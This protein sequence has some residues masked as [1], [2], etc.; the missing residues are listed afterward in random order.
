MTGQETT[1]EADPNPPE[2]EADRTSDEFQTLNSNRASDFEGETP[3]QPCTNGDCP[4]ADDPRH[5]QE[6][7]WIELMSPVPKVHQSITLEPSPGVAQPNPL[8]F[9]EIRDALRPLGIAAHSIEA[10]RFGW[11]QLHEALKDTPNRLSSKLVDL[12]QE[13]EGDDFDAFAEQVEIAGSN[14]TEALDEIDTAK[15]ELQYLEDRIYADQGGDSCE[16]P[17]PAPDVWRA[18]DSMINDSRIHVRPAWASGDCTKDRGE[19]QSWENL[20]LPQDFT[21]SLEELVDQR[22]E[23]YTQTGMDPTSARLQA[24][25]DYDQSLFDFGEHF[26]ETMK[27]A[28]DQ[29]NEG[30]E[31]LHTDIATAQGD[32][33]LE[34]STRTP[35]A[36]TDIGFKLPPPELIPPPEIDPPPISDFGDY[37]PEPVDPPELPAPDS[38]LGGTP[39]IPSSS[40]LEHGG[41]GSPGS[42]T[43]GTGWDADDNPWGA[44]FDDDDEI[45]GGLASGGAGAPSGLPSGAGGIGAPSSAGP[46]GVGGAMIPGGNGGA[47]AG[48]RGAATGARSATGAGRGRPGMM[49]GGGRGAGSS[50]ENEK[51]RETWLNEDEDVW[52]IVNEDDDPYA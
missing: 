7:T 24:C 15:V 28:S 1:F 37:E 48:G 22:A 49:G 44:A 17:F 26:S 4:Y 12:S 34:H 5:Y 33:A 20:G 19:G 23:Q 2:I 42:V 3:R 14:L 8:I 47:G 30:I 11:E 52:G 29:Y 10:V 25:S 51:G 39:T 9:E 35:P 38:N 40:G 41:F 32:P 46:G 16:I 27:R 45:S 50:G 31:A 43:G 18:G 6:E 36:I 21:Q 13:W